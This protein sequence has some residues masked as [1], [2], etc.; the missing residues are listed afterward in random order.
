MVEINAGNGTDLG[1]VQRLRTVN[2]RVVAHI[3]SDPVGRELLRIREDGLL[4]CLQRYVSV[5]DT[6]ILEDEGWVYGDILSPVTE[7][8]PVVEKLAFGSIGLV[9]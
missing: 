5:S 7:L 4:P 1:V 3:G 2:T 8:V 6:V 9:G